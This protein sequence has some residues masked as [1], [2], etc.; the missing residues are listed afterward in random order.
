VSADDPNI[1]HLPARSVWQAMH[2]GVRARCPHCG[3]GA[4]FAGYLRVVDHCAVCGEALHHHRA[5]D[6]PPYFTISIV[7]HIIVGLVLA[8]EVAWSPPL[9]LHLVLWAPLT[10]FLSLALLR[11]IKGVIV[12]LQWAWHMHGFG[13]E[14]EGP[15]HG[16][17][18]PSAWG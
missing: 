4:L 1:V 10:L 7:G 14:N 8:V 2:N 5:D 16:D 15:A 13:G 18:D 17:P 12:G 11:P 6:A 9:W 3:R